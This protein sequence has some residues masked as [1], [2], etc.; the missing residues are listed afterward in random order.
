MA[1]GH[2]TN[3]AGDRD[4]NTATNW[5]GGAAPS[6]NENMIFQSGFSSA[7]SGPNVD[8]AALTLIDLDKLII[9][10]GYTED[11]GS[12]GGQLDISA[13]HVWH[14][15]SGKLWYKDGSGTTDLVTIDSTAS[16]PTTSVFDVSAGTVTR[17]QIL[18]G[19][20]TLA[21]GVTATNVDVGMRSSVPGDANVT[22]GATGTVTALNQWGGTCTCSRAVT[23]ATINAGTLNQDTATITT[24]YVYGGRVNFKFT[25]TITTVYLYGGILDF[26]KGGGAKTITTLYR[27]PGTQLIG[28]TAGA[29]TITNAWDVSDV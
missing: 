7:G 27:T 24:L 17:T 10:P 20:V 22:I 5:S 3:G 14:R 29:V 8:M 28:A 21:S 12:S 1:S 11:V 25:G 9:D 18:R 16:S 19:G 26:T 23:T 6:N 15:G 13:D 4:I 2:W